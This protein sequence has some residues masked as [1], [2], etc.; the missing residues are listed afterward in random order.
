MILEKKKLEEELKQMQTNN[1]TKKGD[2][3][4][5]AGA[6]P[7]AAGNGLYLNPYEGTGVQ[8]YFKELIHKSDMCE[9]S[10]KDYFQILK[11][12]KKGCKNGNGIYLEPYKK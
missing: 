10:K 6:T 5:A 3:G 4:G 9:Q 2:V 11:L 12:L 7:G 1:Q 8:K